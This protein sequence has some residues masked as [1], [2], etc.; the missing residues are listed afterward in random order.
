AR[1]DVEPLDVAAESVLLRRVGDRRAQHLLDVARDALAREL[2]RRQRGVD[3][4][5]ADEVE[6]QAGL[7]GRRPDVARGGVGFDRHHAPAFG[8][9]APAPAPAGAAAATAAALSLFVVCPLNCRVGANSPSLCPTMFSVTYT[10][11][12]LRPLCTAIVWPT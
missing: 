3:V 7:L 11:M 10:G 6:H 4:A 5:A 12:N 9:A 8:A 2:Q 1:L